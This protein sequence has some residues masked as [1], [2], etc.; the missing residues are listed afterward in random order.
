MTEISSTLKSRDTEEWLDILFTRPVGYLWMLL[1]KRLGVHPNAVTALSMLL[2][3]SAGVCFFFGPATSSHW[4]T[5]NIMGVLLLVWANLLDSADGQLARATGKTTQLGRI[6]DGTAG[7]IWYFVIY[8]AI[9]LRLW[10]Q[11]IPLT[12]IHWG[13]IGF[14]IG[15]FDGFVAHTRQ[16]RLAD[17]YRGIHLYFINNA[18]GELDNYNQQLAIYKQMTWRGGPLNAFCKFFQALYVNYVHEQEKT[19]PQFQCLRRKLSEKYL[20]A[21]PQSF[22]QRFRQLS[23]PILWCTNALTF[24]QRAIALYIACLL[25]LPWLLFV[26]EIFY[27]GGIYFYMKG[28]HECFCR[29]L[30]QEL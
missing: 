29:K 12:H 23:Y 28:R 6:L 15:C 7:D 22:C 11:E 3:A 26:V 25:N 27:L 1:F 24:N 17:Y 5:I 20:I 16:C 19:T 14:A 30:C 18:R 13:W 21:I 10:N 2:G 8:W 9:V 4:L